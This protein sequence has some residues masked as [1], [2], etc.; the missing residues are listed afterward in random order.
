[1]VRLSSGGR[2]PRRNDF[3]RSK[4]NLEGIGSP[5]T[6][7]TEGKHPASTEGGSGFQE[8]KRRRDAKHARKARNLTDLSRSLA[9]PVTEG[10]RIRTRVSLN[11]ERD[12]KIRDPKN[13]ENRS[14]KIKLGNEKNWVA[15]DSFLSSELH[16]VKIYFW[17]ALGESKRCN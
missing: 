7:R 1:V 9:E 8:K 17:K 14:N 4:Q 13:N 11:E 2:K 16:H 6:D 12:R 3:G 15:G 5:P 10:Q